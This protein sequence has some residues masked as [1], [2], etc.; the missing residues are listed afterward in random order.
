MLL[1]CWKLNKEG[2]LEAQEGCFVD[3]KLSS[4]HHPRAFLVSAPTW[5]L[6]FVQISPAFHAVSL[7]NRCTPDFSLSS[8]PCVFL[9]LLLWWCEKTWGKGES[10]EWQPRLCAREGETNAI[11]K[12]IWSKNLVQNSSEQHLSSL[13]KH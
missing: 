3:G 2:G 12:L 9:R 13:V 10:N 6:N 5:F 4:D 1:V 8:P 7:A 11:R